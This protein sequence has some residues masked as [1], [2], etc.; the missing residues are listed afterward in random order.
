MPKKAFYP[1]KNFS[2]DNEI[3]CL[4]SISYVIAKIVTYF[5]FIFT[6]EIWFI[7]AGYLASLWVFTQ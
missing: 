7:F 5:I 1:A 4:N 2:C 6:C 3:F